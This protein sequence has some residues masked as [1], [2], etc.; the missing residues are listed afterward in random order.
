[1]ATKIPAF[2][3]TGQYRTE[4]RGG[5]WYIYLLTSG[6]LRMNYAKSGVSACVVGGGASG[7]AQTTPPHEDRG[8]PGGRGGAVVNRTGLSVAAGQAYNVVVGAGGSNP[9][10]GTFAPGGASSIFVIYASGGSAS[11]GQG[12]GQAGANGTH[13]FGDAGLPRYGAQGGAGGRDYS[14]GGNGGAD[15]GGKGASG[16]S[17]GVRGADATAGAANTGA[18]GGGA[19]E[20]YR[21][22]DSRFNAHGGNAASGGSGIVILRGTQDDNIPVIFNGTLLADI[23]YNGTKIT[24]LIYDGT[25][26]F[27]NARQEIRRRWKCRK[28]KRLLFV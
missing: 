1:M 3:Y 23:V 18:G 24:G 9:P 26:I 8:M 7:E 25:R 11:T 15:G 17:P 10:A 19:G 16:G 27:A 6:V 12:S 22:D 13:A 2:S 14:A 5:T 20:F 4:M 28:S 21:D